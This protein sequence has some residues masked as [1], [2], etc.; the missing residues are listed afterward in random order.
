MRVHDLPGFH[1]F[2]SGRLPGWESWGI[3]ASCGELLLVAGCAIGGVSAEPVR[4]ATGLQH[5]KRRVAD[6]LR[7]SWTCKLHHRISYNRGYD[8]L[9]QLLVFFFDPLVSPKSFLSGDKV[10]C[11]RALNTFNGPTLATWQKSSLQ[12]GC[13]WWKWEKRVDIWG[14]CRECESIESINQLNLWI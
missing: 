14:K 11:W 5:C 2:T 13:G 9:C 3:V 8:I 10:G 7:S 12:L 4:L 1:H 6:I